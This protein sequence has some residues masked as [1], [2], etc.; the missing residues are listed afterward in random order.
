[1]GLMRNGG[2][3]WGDASKMNS[4][5]APANFT[6][7]QLFSACKAATLRDAGNAKT[8]DPNKIMMK[9]HF[10]WDTRRLHKLNAF[11]LTRKGALST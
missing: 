8:S 10:I 2:F 9:L 3:R 6:H 1:M 7:P 4:R 11:W 5:L